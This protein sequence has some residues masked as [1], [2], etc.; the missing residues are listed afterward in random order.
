MTHGLSRAV[1]VVLAAGCS[2]AVTAQITTPQVREIDLRKLPR[3]PVWKPGDPIREMPDM[4]RTDAPAPTSLTLDG[5]TLRV[6]NGALAVMAADG[7]LTAG[8]IAF[9]SLWPDGADPCGVEVEWAPAIQ[10]DREA[11]RWIVSQRIQP[12]GAGAAQRTPLCVAVSRTPDLVAGG[13]WLYEFRL[14]LTL[15]AP[16]LDVT[17]DVYRVP[18]IADGKAVWATFDRAAMLEGKPSGFTVSPR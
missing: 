14:P 17:T 9:R 6:V 4:R 8:P 11:R 1:L 16:A 3:S 5:Q 18:G 10:V 13:W 2:A 7:S 15:D 12:V